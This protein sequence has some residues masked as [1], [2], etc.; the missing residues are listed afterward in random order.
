MLCMREL[1]SNR[2]VNVQFQ[3]ERVAKIQQLYNQG[4]TLKTECTSY[5]SRPKCDQ[6]L[7]SGVSR[8]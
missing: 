4:G 1:Q 8:M 6:A 7:M 2:S 5:D 3:G